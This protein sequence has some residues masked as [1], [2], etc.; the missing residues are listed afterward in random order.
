MKLVVALVLALIGWAI[1]GFI[2]LVGIAIA[3]AVF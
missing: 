2:V 3:R 1:V